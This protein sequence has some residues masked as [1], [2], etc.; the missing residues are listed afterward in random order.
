MTG[1]ELKTLVGATLVRR[2]GKKVQIKVDARFK[3]W[4]RRHQHLL[5][6]ALR[7]PADDVDLREG[8]SEDR[9]KALGFAFD[10]EMSGFIFPF[11]DEAGERVLLGIE[12]APAPLEDVPLI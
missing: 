6:R 11:G 4:A 7:R 2:S 9:L 8:V 5:R 1:R 12:Q 10:S 3:V